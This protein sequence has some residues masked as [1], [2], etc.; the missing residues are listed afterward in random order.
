[1]L[2]C[3]VLVCVQSW[4]MPALCCNSGGI[5]P[6]SPG[7]RFWTAL[8][9]GMLLDLSDKRPSAYAQRFRR[10]GPVSPALAEDCRNMTSYHFIKGPGGRYRGD[11]ISGAPPY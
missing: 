8:F 1:M 11:A 6:E 2:W 10:P 4:L 7:V 3:A 5:L 9:Y